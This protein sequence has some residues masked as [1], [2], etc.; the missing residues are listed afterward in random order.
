MLQRGT[1]Q[2]AWLVV[3]HDDWN[4]VSK[5]FFGVSVHFIVDPVGWACSKLALGLAVPTGHGAEACARAAWVVMR[6][7]YIFQEDIDRN[8]N[9]T[10]NTSVPTGRL[11]AGCNGTYDMHVANLVADHAAPVRQACLLRE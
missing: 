4:F 1:N 6:R 5:Q 2:V 9:E 11:L 10:S 8:V 7:T 3:C